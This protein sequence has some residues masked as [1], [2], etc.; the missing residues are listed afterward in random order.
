MCLARPPFLDFII[1]AA[2]AFYGMRGTKQRATF[3]APLRLARGADVGL[4]LGADARAARAC[5][6]EIATNVAL[7]DGVPARA[8][9]RHDLLVED[10]VIERVIDVAVDRLDL[11]LELE[12]NRDIDGRGTE[13]LELRAQAIYRLEFPFLEL[14]LLLDGFE[15]LLEFRNLLLVPFLL[16]CLDGFGCFR[17][18]LL[19]VVLQDAHL[20]LEPGLQPALDLARACLDAIQELR[21]CLLDEHIDLLLRDLE[22]LSRHGHVVHEA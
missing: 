3:L 4:A 8:Y 7:I 6:V 18:Q 15:L 11:A 2:I 14:L 21:G 19:V 5:K 17:F 22:Q 9:R 10:V 13:H 12:E 20:L 1:S 16:R